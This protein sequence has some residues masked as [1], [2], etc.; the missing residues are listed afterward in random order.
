MTRIHTYW[1][2]LSLPSLVFIILGGF[3]DY[4]SQP[5]PEL[6]SAIPELRERL[7][8]IEQDFY[9]LADTPGLVRSLVADNFDQELYQRLAEKDYSILVYQNQQLVYWNKNDINLAPHEIEKYPV[10]INF[11]E[12]K[13]GFYQVIRIPFESSIQNNLSLIHI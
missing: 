10:G 3:G 4:F 7:T 11:D 12:M 8:E 9:V 13:N 5:T 6:E 1:K 2:Y